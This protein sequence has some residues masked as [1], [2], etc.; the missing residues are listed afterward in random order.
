MSVLLYDQAKS[1]FFCEKS[2]NLTLF[3]MG[4]IK[5]I[6]PIDYGRAI[7]VECPEWADFS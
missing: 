7:L 2:A 1:Q 5:T 6:P 3:Y 4:G